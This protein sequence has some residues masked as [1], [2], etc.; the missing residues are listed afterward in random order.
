MKDFI[1][2]EQAIALK[3]LGF[4]EPCFGYFS[5]EE[6]II[7]GRYKNSEHGRSISS[8]L[9]QQ[10]FRFFRENHD[11]RIWIESNY[12]V[13]KF[14]YVIATTNPN[15]INKQFNDFSGYNTYEEAELACLIKLIEIVKTKQP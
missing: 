6:L 13:L 11:L 14:E 7:E 5:Y 15:F 2:Y 1:P 4:N 10:A 12:G 3:E 9:F 8:P